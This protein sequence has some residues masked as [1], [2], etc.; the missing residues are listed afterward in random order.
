MKN[1]R[2]AIMS[3]LLI[4]C[5]IMGL[6][7]A[8][9]TD[10]MDINGSV[11]MNVNDVTDGNVYFSAARAL[12]PD[13]QQ[14]ANTAN[15]NPNNPDKASFT[16]KNLVSESQ[17]A[18]FEFDVTNSNTVDM[19]V[20]IDTSQNMYVTTDASTYYELT[21]TWKTGSAQQDGYVLIPASGTVTVNVLVHMIDTPDRVLNASF[22]VT[23]E[24]VDAETYGINT[25][26]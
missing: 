9:F 16:V 26:P 19:Y 18:N 21:P 24:V 6:G 13:A 12:N 23:L 15:I 22:L 1:R 7:Y 8:A 11:E 17:Q 4:A 20:K 5:L 14:V 10:Y 2:K 3:F 25:T